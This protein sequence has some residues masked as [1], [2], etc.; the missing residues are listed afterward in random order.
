MDIFNFDLPEENEK[1]PELDA[2][3]TFMNDQ[4]HDI[5]ESRHNNTLRS[6]LE[7]N[8]IKYYEDKTK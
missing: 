8:N 5:E 4:L 3:F 7:D 6:I 1:F 2:W